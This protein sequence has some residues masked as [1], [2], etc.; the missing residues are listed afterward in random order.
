MLEPKKKMYDKSG[1]RIAAALNRRNMEGYYCSTA[2]EAAMA[3]A[4]PTSA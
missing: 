2:A 1:A 3:A 4:T